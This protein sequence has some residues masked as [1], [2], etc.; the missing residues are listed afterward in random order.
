[1]LNRKPTSSEKSNWNSKLTNGS[2]TPAQLVQSLMA[3]H[4]RH[5]QLVDG[6]YQEYFNRKADKGGE[7][8]WTGELDKSARTQENVEIEL[9]S[10]VEYYNLRHS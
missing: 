5:L 9:L 3:S 1:L 7:T 6:F 2:A 8:F 4:E 10:S